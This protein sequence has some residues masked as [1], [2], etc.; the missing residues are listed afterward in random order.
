MM[1]FSKYTKQGSLLSPLSGS[2]LCLVAIMCIIS[3]KKPWIG[4]VRDEVKS[5]SDL[6]LSS[7]MIP[8]VICEQHFIEN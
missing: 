6:A 1:I 5:I 7:G 8:V 4:S 3:Y 2:Q